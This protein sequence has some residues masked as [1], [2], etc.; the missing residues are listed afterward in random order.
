MTNALNI[1]IPKNTDDRIMKLARFGMAAKGAVY[2]ILGVLTT[3][4]AFNI[5]GQNANKSDTLKFLHEQ[6]FGKILL[7]ILAI[8]LLCYV[9]WRF[10]Q[11]FKDPEDKG[12]DKKAIFTRIGYAASGVVYGILTFEAVRMLFKGGSSGGGGNQNQE[13]VSQLLGKPG[14]QILVGIVAA[15]F[16]GKAIYQFY[17]AFSGKFKKKIQDSGLDNRVKK[18]LRNAG[19][20]GYIARGVVIGIIGF[21][22]LR[23]AIQADASEAEGSEGAFKFIESSPYGP[24]LLAIV[25]IG[26][27]CYGIYMFVKARYRIMPN[28]L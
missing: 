21:L 14:G 15:I 26:L 6:P 8:G 11:A 5:G 22:F 10:I 27:V 19:M 4:A 23:A 1:T 13:L 16:I 20:V 9:I 18:I 28:S 7:G 2:C 12:T 17:R 25:A 3:L 24:Y